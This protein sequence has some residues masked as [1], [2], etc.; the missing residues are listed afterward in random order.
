MTE[1]VPVLR[2][3]D[4]LLVSI[5]VDLEDQTVL[6]LQ[7]DLAEQIVAKSARGVV[8][9]ITAVEIVDSFV[10]RMLATIASISRLLDAETVVVGMRPAVAITLVELGLS[11][12]GVRTALDLE[13]GLALLRRSAT[14]ADLP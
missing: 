12:G 8:I 10:G 3:G 4:I 5:Q 2:I 13:K 9:D 6:D 14:G 7:E 1:R 11:L